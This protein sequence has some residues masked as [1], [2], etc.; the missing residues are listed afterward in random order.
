[1]FLRKY[2][3]LIAALLMMFSLNAGE[4]MMSDYQDVS[5]EEAKMM[6][7]ENPDLIVIDVSPIWHKGHLPGAVNFAWGD[8]SFAEAVPEWDKEAMYLIYC[9]GDAPAIAAAKHLIEKGFSH[10]YRLEGNYSAW[11]EAGYPIEK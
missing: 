2:I 9:H 10:V 8:G 3:V 6:I 11:V 7:E 4:H 5:P 1:M